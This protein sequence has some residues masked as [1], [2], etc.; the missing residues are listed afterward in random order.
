M[1]AI[2]DVRDVLFS[3][4]ALNYSGLNFYLFHVSLFL[5]CLN[6]AIHRRTENALKQLVYTYGGST[7]AGALIG[8]TPFIFTNKL[9]IPTHIL[10]R[11]VVFLAPRELFQTFLVDWTLRVGM[12]LCR[13]MIA[14]TW[15]NHTERVFG[16]QTGLEGVLIGTVA[17]TFG[18]VLG[19]LSL[20]PIFSTTFLGLLFAMLAYQ[21]AFERNSPEEENLAR[22]FVVVWMVVIQ[23]IIPRLLS[24]V[25][26]AFGSRASVKTKVE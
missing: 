6:I 11:L 15:L 25:R 7:L 19:S 9:A 12:E 21:F 4:L 24:S 3:I 1:A 16:K 23:H 18:A 14:T 20:R 8:V 2:E 10:A 17:G 26:R 22:S 5:F 13:C